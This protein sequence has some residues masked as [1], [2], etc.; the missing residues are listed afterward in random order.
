MAAITVDVFEAPPPP[1]PPKRVSINL[2]LDWK[3]ARELRTVVGVVHWNS[4]EWARTLHTLLG[5]CGIAS[6]EPSVP[7][8]PTT[9]VPVFK[10][11]T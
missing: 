5:N 4:H 2:D 1:Q 10:V 8:N 7:L 9:I 11:Q 3:E 6:G